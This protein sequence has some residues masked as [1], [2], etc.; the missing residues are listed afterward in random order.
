[1]SEASAT[2]I[3]PYLIDFRKIGEPGIGYISV[4]EKNLLPFS[5][6]RVYWTYFTPESVV[7]GRHAHHALAQ[8]LVAAAGR[9]IVNTE[10]Q[11]GSMDT[12]KLETADSGVYIPPYCW[13]TMQYS[14]NAV[15]I[16]LASM[17]YKE[18]DYIRD[19]QTFKSGATERN[20]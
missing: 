7:R 9:I 12:F 11:D 2:L 20:G 3:K 4:A 14:H 18:T 1:M 15:Q 5:V 13:H 16:S 19:Y 8:I 10:M 17:E 6:Q